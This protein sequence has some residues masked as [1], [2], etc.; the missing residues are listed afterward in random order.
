MT[1]AEL[2]AIE[3]RATVALGGREIRRILSLWTQTLAPPVATGLLFLG[4]FGGAL[5]SRVGAVEG[6]DYLAFVLPGVLVMTVAAQS[7]HNNSTSLFQAK[8]EGYIEDV[9]TSPLRG[10]QL[11]AS[12]AAGGFVRAL[13]AA[14][15]IAAAASPWAGGIEDPVVAALA[16]VLSA[17]LFSLLGVIVGVWAET[18]DQHAFVANLVVT[19]LAL[20]AGVFY[21]AD[22]LSEP[23]RTLTRLDPI[24]YLV[25][26][27]RAGFTGVHDAPVALSLAAASAAS[28]AS[29]A[30]AVAVL[31]RGWRLKP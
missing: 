27:T 5:G 4:I 30:L 9:L 18:F 28:A 17:L 25:D 22:S 11:A 6:V 19:P 13:L 3:R 14:A 21:S 10:W 1:R 29:F 23:W 12:F 8:S 16:L 20:I 7:F 24:Y 31:A 15:L 2:R 26:A